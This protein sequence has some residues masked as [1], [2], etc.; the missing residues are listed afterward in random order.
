M[1]KLAIITVEKGFDSSFCVVRDNSCAT[2][3]ESSP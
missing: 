3:K 2:I 1:E